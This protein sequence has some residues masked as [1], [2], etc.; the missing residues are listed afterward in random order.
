MLPLIDGKEDDGE[1]FHSGFM[2]NGQLLGG[3]YVMD[4]DDDDDDDEDDE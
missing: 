1:Y 2:K 4:D 3:S